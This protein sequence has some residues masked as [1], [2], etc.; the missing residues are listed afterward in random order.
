MN[1]S[2]AYDLYKAYKLLEKMLKEFDK[3]NKEIYI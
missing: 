3:L 1:T 2:Y